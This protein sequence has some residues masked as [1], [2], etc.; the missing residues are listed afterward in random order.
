M[1]KDKKRVAAVATRFSW[2]LFL[3][4]Q[5]VYNGSTYIDFR[6]F[7]NNFMA[8]LGES[9]ARLFSPLL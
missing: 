4:T 8:R 2:C 9:L 7:E 1:L 6:S 5:C 3:K